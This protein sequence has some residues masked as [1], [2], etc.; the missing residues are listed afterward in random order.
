MGRA[1][2]LLPLLAALAGCGASDEAGNGAAPPP[3]P[4]AALNQQPVRDEH[5]TAALTPQWLAGSWQTEQGDCS[6]GDTF[7]TLAPDGRYAFMQETGRWALAGD[8]LT[9]EVTQ[10]ADDGSGAGQR[11]TNRVVIVGPNEAEFHME[12]G[13]PIRVYRC[14]GE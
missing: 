8:Q 12:G 1:I 10:G 6:A 5:R 4:S 11:N 14:H 9:I 7:V 2:V 13:D 3:A